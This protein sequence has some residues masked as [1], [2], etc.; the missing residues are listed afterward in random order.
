MRKLKLQ[1]QVTLDGYVAGPNREM[2]WVTFN[3]DD[4]LNQYVTELTETVDC[5]LLGRK[6]AEGF[7]PH[8]A[9]LPEGEDPAGVQKMNDTAKVVFTGTI[10]TSN[11]ANTVLATGSLVDE[12]SRLKQQAGKD[13]ITYGGASFAS[14]LVKHGL[15]DEYHLF[16]NPVSIGCGLSIFKEIESPHNLALKHSMA[17]PCGI[18][19]LCYV[20]KLV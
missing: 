16:V 20:P 4:Q 1:M 7:I 10:K 9:A 12:V 5:M 17:F 8:W 2:D 11:W 3:W 18:V 13:M 15:I 19:A 14:A 6:L